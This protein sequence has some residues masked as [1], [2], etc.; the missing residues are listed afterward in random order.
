MDEEERLTQWSIDLFTP[1]QQ[2]AWASYEA[3]YLAF[4]QASEV[5]DAAWKLVL[6]RHGVKFS[7]KFADRLANIPSYETAVRTHCG[8]TVKSLLRKYSAASFEFRAV[9]GLMDSNR[10]RVSSLMLDQPVLLRDTFGII[11]DAHDQDHLVFLPDELAQER[12]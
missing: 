9:A 2:A 1:E 8:G 11:V 12:N 3:S 7:R 6:K 10:S 5:L 4:T